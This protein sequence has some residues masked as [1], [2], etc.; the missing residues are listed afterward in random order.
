VHDRAGHLEGNRDQH[1]GMMEALLGVVL[2][3]GA[4]L[5]IKTA[6]Y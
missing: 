4:Q 3:T 6:F 5:Q 2:G 1:R